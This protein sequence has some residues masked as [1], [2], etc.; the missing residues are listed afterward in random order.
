ML[1]RKN[2]PD[3][4]GDILRDLSRAAGYQ[5]LTPLQTAA[6]PPL[7]AGKDLLLEADRGEG[8][9]L[10]L[11]APPFLRRKPARESLPQALILVPSRESLQE[12]QALLRNIQSWAGSRGPHSGTVLGLED[13]PRREISILKGADLIIA[14]PARII[15][16]YRRDSL[17]LEGIRYLAADLPPEDQDPGF[18]KDLDFIQ[19]KIRRKAQTVLV[20]SPIPEDPAPLA[21]RL[22]HPA[23]LTREDRQQPPEEKRKTPSKKET[24]MKDLEEIKEEAEKIVQKIQ[25]DEDIQEMN[26]YKKAFKKAFPRLRRG[27]AAGFLLKE[28]L[29][30][31]GSSRSRRNSRPAKNRNSGS[32]GKTAGQREGDIDLFISVGKNRRVYP[33]DIIGLF[34][35]TEAVE[36]EDI[37]EIR[38]L[39]SYSFAGVSQAKAAELIEK[40]NG[41][42]FRGRS[43][44]VNYSRK[45]NR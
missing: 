18:L 30:G 14:T 16:H 32:A 41:T 20:C 19:T 5:S 1:F 2:Q 43:L 3:P 9:A 42:E 33:K 29:E 6:L 21:E 36:R 12:H 38:I 7:G 8:K 13:S 4:P 11:Q 45:K 28:Y 23:I 39:D 44:T 27:Y 35:S 40:L 22:H 26:D 10:V 37:G 25:F 17:S 34:M 15:D 31:N 24:P